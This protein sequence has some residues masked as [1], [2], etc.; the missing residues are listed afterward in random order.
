V[1]AT[2]LSRQCGYSAVSLVSRMNFFS[3]DR[4]LVS[5][6]EFFSTWRSRL[7]PHSSKDE[8]GGSPR[9]SST[10]V[11]RV[12]PHAPRWSRPRHAL[13]H[14]IGLTRRTSPGRG[15]Q[16]LLICLKPAIRGSS[17]LPPI[18]NDAP[19]TIGRSGFLKADDGGKHTKDEQE[20]PH[21]K[22]QNKYSQTQIA[23]QV[24]YSRIVPPPVE[25]ASRKKFGSRE[26]YSF[27]ICHG[28]LLCQPVA[29]LLLLHP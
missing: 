8:A 25:R 16:A 12:V 21:C 3:M 15:R 19:R 5:P 6:N 11:F 29:N 27:L 7:A 24:F 10:E 17:P 1:I 22:L 26:K 2:L 14:R 23:I 13:V 20:N 28:H 18:V 4:L 9:I